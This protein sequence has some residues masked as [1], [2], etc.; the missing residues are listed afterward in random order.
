MGKCTFGQVLECWDRESN[1]MV[2]VK[3]VHEF[4]SFVKQQ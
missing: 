2:A 3:I 1:E 4:R